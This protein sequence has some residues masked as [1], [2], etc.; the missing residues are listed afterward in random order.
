MVRGVTR[1]PEKGPP[2]I[3]KLKLTR[4]Q[5]REERVPGGAAAAELAASGCVRGQG[6][7]GGEAG[8]GRGGGVGSLAGAAEEWAALWASQHDALEHRALS[9][10]AMMP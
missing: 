9:R 8:E 4:R 7:Q 2:V 5:G 3:L 1:E 6:G 10:I